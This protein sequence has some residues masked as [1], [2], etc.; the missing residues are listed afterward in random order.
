MKQ[1]S[2][3]LRTEPNTLPTTAP[4]N[5]KEIARFEP[6]AIFE[7]EKSKEKLTEPRTQPNIAASSDQEIA[8][9]EPRA[10]LETEVQRQADRTKKSAQKDTQK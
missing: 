2:K 4:E 8:R 9:F 6:R 7:S 5:D 10:A 3:E 1:R